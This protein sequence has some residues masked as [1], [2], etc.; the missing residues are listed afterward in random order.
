M[1]SI[2]TEVGFNTL[3][4]PFTLSE[5]YQDTLESHL[6]QQLK[7]VK[8]GSYVTNF[9]DDADEALRYSLMRPALC[10]YVHGIE[11]AIIC[12]IEQEEGLDI[13]ED[14]GYGRGRGF[15]GL[16]GELEDTGKVSQTTSEALKTMNT[17]R[18]W[19]AHHKSGRISEIEVRRVKQRFAILLEELFL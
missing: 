2:A 15:P 11:W 18:I 3:R 16:I 9:A 8:Y 10:A 5:N 4:E 7:D 14:E 1:R 12:H 6:R 13:M 19:M 17:E